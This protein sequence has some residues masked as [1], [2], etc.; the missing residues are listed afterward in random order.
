MDDD[1]ETKTVV[2]APLTVAHETITA[3]ALK[4]L[5]SSGLNSAAAISDVE[6]PTLESIALEMQALHVTVMRLEAIVSRIA[7]TF[8]RNIAADVDAAIEKASSVE[9][10]A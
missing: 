9:V 6:P 1:Q 4:A 5:Q 3:A 8:Y 2:K 10:K 7:G